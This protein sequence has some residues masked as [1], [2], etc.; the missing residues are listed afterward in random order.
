LTIDGR[1]KNSKPE[2]L[3][4]SEVSGAFDALLRQLL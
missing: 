4:E 3:E 2:P 1:V